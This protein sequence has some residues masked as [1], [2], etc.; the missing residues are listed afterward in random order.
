MKK[1]LLAC[2]L[3]V[4]VSAPLFAQTGSTVREDRIWNYIYVSSTDC[5]YAPTPM[6]GFRFDGTTEWKGRKYLIFRDNEG[7]DLC[8]LR[9]EGG[10]VY[11]ALEYYIDGDIPGSQEVETPDEVLLY[12]FDAKP[13]ESYLTMPYGPEFYGELAETT[14][15][16]AYSIEVNGET[17]R[18]QEVDIKID[19][20]TNHFTFVE[21][22][23][24]LDGYISEPAGLPAMPSIYSNSIHLATWNTPDGDILF[25]LSDI[26]PRGLTVNEAQVWNYTVETLSEGKT[27]ASVSDSGY[28]FK[29]LVREDGRPYLQF[30]NGDDEVMA[31]MRQDGEN[32]YLH[33]DK[34]M[35]EQMKYLHLIYNE[36]ESYQE[37]L[38][39]VLLYASDV[40]AGNYYNSISYLSA[41]GDA[42][43]FMLYDIE[44]SE[45]FPQRVGVVDFNMQKIP[46]DISIVS[47]AGMSRGYL[48]RPQPFMEESDSPCTVALLESLTFNNIYPFYTREDFSSAVNG[49]HGVK[50]QKT[51]ISYSGGVV[52]AADGAEVAVYDMA[53]KRVAQG[54]GS[55][56]TASLQPGVYIVK[57]A[58][59]ALKITVK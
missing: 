46:G 59:A 49:V 47:R 52:I 35:Q 28:H 5:V 19:D 8:H 16:D 7:N 13:G 55:L 2:G 45:S 36:G 15:T 12:D 54:R 41:D 11:L 39:E 31:L 30:R 4:A 17:F 6:D 40:A 34:D 27:V 1:H 14:V 9:Q 26:N 43:D 44:I 42:T 38:T 22:I 24:S 53:E 51:D 23:G 48:H 37:P 29:G 57:A 56:S 18:C 20:N 10:K 25:K 50:S 32:V 58:A 21:G 3:V 33:L